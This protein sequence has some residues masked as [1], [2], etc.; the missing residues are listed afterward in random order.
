MPFY[1]ALAQ[2]AVDADTIV[3]PVAI[4]YRDQHGEPSAAAP[5]L[6][7]QTFVDSLRAILQEPVIR[8]ELFFGEPFPA[9]AGH[10]AR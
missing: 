9:S 6:G 7:D 8:A 5:F 10:A 2:A 1:P 4:R 3:Q